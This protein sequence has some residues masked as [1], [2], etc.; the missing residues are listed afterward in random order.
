VSTAAYDVRVAPIVVRSVVIA[1][2]IVGVAIGPILYG[3]WAQYLRFIA[4]HRLHAPDLSPLLRAPPVIQAHLV[5]VLAAVATGIVQMS[6]VKGTQLHR[7]LGW[8]WSVFMMLTATSAL[9]I[10]S[11]GSTL[12]FLKLFA[13]IT[14]GSVPAAVISARSHE[15]GRHARIMTSLFV[16]GVGVAGVLAFLPGR[17]MWQ[18][19]FG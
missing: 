14:L 12:I 19:L 18:V 17:L 6:G 1:M 4:G 13:L 2:V 16:G 15:V 3:H 9:F 8:S 10:S 5:A 11:Q 7:V